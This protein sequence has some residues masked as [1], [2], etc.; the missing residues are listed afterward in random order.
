MEEEN[1][2]DIAYIYS[3]DYENKIC[4][5]CQG[6]FPRWLSINNAII[7]C[8]NCAER[9]SKLGFNISY[10]REISDNWDPYLLSFIH[11]GGNGRFIRFSNDYK[12]SQLPIEEKYRTKAGEYYR[13]LILS[14]VIA[15]MPPDVIL[16][17]TALEECDNTIHFPEFDNYQLFKGEKL[18][19][20]SGS[21]THAFSESFKTAGQYIN[22]TDIKE[23]I[24]DGSSKAFTVMKD[25]SGVVYD[26]SKPVVSYLKTKAVQGAG[27]FINQLTYGLS[28]YQ[29]MQYQKKSLA[30]AREMAEKKRFQTQTSSQQ[31]SE[32]DNS[33]MYPNQQQFYFNANLTGN[34]INERMN[35]NP[36]QKLTNKSNIPQ[37]QLIQNEQSVLMQ[38]NIGKE[39]VQTKDH[40]DKKDN[41]IQSKVNQNY[42]II[43]EGDKVNNIPQLQQRNEKNN[44]DLD[45]MDDIN[46]H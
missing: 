44:N 10:V 26:Y 2:P 21:V 37:P 5:D 20:K 14:E 46:Y 16:Q 38:S 40:E 22:N 36:E 24:I 4:L 1:N 42:G 3:L 13:K 31:Y 9:H 8:K 39:E 41:D 45:Q 15:D 27:Y 19:Y 18:S 30:K 6:A 7:I 29:N 17:N 32:N 11:R 33:S 35:I 34:Q 43:I 12:L 25:V 23:K 28:E